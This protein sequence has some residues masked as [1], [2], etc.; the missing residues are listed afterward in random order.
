MKAFLTICIALLAIGS[1]QDAK[2]QFAVGPE[3][4][5]SFDGTNFFVGVNGTSP[6]DLGG[7]IL[8]AN[9]AGDYY[10][11]DN[12]SFS[13][14]DAD[15][16]QITVEGSLN[17]SVAE[18]ESY[19][20][21]VGAGLAMSRTSVSVTGLESQSDTSASFLLKGGADF[22][23]ES[24]FAPFGELVYYFNGSNLAARAGIRFAF[25]GE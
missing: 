11:I 19:Y 24:A 17:F 3:V 14:V 12:T 18:Q 10:L 9:V 7:L 1:T 15:A 5:L 16:S 22:I 21:Y 13:G 4:G 20:P 2:A 25:G 23:T 6:V 8:T